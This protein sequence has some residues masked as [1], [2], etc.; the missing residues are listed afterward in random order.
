MS[1]GQWASLLNI[2]FYLALPTHY[3][4]LLNT[5]LTLHQLPSQ[6]AVVGECEK[7]GHLHTSQDSAAEA[8]ARSCSALL[9]GAGSISPLADTGRDLLGC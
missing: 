1:V 7:G 6:L 9:V 4:V 3:Y 5:H 8:A 2:H